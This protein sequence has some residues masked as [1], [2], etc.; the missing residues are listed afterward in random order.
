MYALGFILA[1][2]FGAWRFG[3]RVCVGPGTYVGFRFLSWGVRVYSNSIL[4][5]A[6]WRRQRKNQSDM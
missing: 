2:G 3:I 6:Q 5:A 4:A 1:V